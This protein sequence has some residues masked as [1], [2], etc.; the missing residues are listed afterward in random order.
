[1]VRNFRSNKPIRLRGLT[2]YAIAWRRCSTMWVRS[3]RHRWKSLHCSLN[4]FLRSHVLRSDPRTQ[5][6]FTVFRFRIIAAVG[7]VALVGDELSSLLSLLDR[8]ILRWKEGG[9][10]DGCPS[11]V[12]VGASA[13]L[14][15]CL[16][17]EL[18]PSIIFQK[19]LV[20]CVDA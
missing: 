12:R 18:Y 7:L 8:G 13:V 19:L 4:C 14:H 17:Y 10:M 2:L 6:G 15:S 20:C 11:L 16:V 3:N 5:V 1:M 9:W